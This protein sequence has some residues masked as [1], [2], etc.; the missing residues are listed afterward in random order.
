MCRNLPGKRHA[1]QVSVILRPAPR[2][3][4]GVTLPS[5][6]E[7]FIV[8][9][10]VSVNCRYDVALFDRNEIE[11]VSLVHLYHRLFLIDF[12]SRNGRIAHMRP[13]ADARGAYVIT[14]LI[15][16]DTHLDLQTSRTRA[17]P[18]RVGYVIGY[19]RRYG[20]GKRNSHY[21][22]PILLPSR[23][24]LS[25]CALRTVRSVC[26]SPPHAHCFEMCFIVNAELGSRS[27]RAGARLDVYQLILKRLSEEDEL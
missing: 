18:C 6:V 20:D 17:V 4:P 7:R 24:P 26:L 27:Q 9:S 12:G 10:T 23:R 25:S 22:T 1:S 2:P 14:G 8:H 3:A 15:L 13:T 5:H 11:T 16:A 19:A 21:F